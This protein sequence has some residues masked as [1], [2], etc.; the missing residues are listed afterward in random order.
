M[1]T[2]LNSVLGLHRT[3]SRVSVTSIAS[4]AETADTTNAYRRFCENLYQSGV[5]E[6]MVRQKEKEILEILRPQRVVASSQV[7]NSNIGDQS[8][9]LGAGCSNAKLPYIYVRPLTH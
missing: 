1:R 6:D 5:T 7:E 9:L 8:Q 3:S 2:Q 4:F